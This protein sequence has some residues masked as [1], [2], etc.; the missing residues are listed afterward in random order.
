MFLFDCVCVS[1]QEFGQI[2]NTIEGLRN[3]NDN[4]KGGHNAP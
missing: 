4:P 2:E 1:V 3:N